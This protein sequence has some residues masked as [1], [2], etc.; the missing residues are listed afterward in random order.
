[1]AEEAHARPGGGEPRSGRGQH[2]VTGG[3]QLA[4]RGGRQPRDHAHH[5]HRHLAD[6]HHHLLAG[7]EYLH[8]VAVTLL[9]R[10]L[11]EVVPGAEHLALAAQH[12]GPDR[13][14]L[15]GAAEVLQEAVHHGEGEAVPGGGAGQ[16]DGRHPGLR[17]RRGQPPHGGRPPGGAQQP[18]AVHHGVL[19][20][21]VTAVSH[22][23]A[24]AA[25]ACVW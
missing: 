12:D 24:T 19:V 7:V 18:A 6:Q 1:M 21:G 5:G 9:R 15:G 25:A 13:L 23:L 10:H 11:L 16:R 8:V 4:A 20:T 14:V 22:C 3:H 2:Q 17:P